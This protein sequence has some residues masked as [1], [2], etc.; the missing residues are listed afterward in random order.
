MQI[1]FS[2]QVWR[3]QARGHPEGAAGPEGCPPRLIPTHKVRK[4]PI[5]A[6]T[7]ESVG[8]T[9]AVWAIIP[10]GGHSYTKTP[11]GMFCLYGK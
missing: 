8:I 1:G 6:S 5:S 7:D 4:N 9:F 11:H 10:W 2:D 3:G